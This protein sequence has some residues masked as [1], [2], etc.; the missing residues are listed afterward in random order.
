[1]VIVKRRSAASDWPVSS[2]SISA[3]QILVLNSTNAVSTDNGPFASTYPS[4]TVITLGTSTDTNANTA[5]YVAYCFAPVAGY[6]AFGS[7]TGN[8]SSDGTFVF[9][10]FR[11]RFIMIKR[12]DTAE[13]WYMLDTS[14]NTI[15]LAVN[16]LDARAS[17]AETTADFF[18][19]LSNGFKLRTTGGY[20]NASGGTYIYMAFAESPF[21]YANAR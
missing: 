19:I 5:T 14:R 12:T 17:G 11:P 4:S 6:S 2:R 13:G 3:G 20:A 8:G 15:N 21:K 7:Y 18:D 10:G 1:M 9:T 16:Y